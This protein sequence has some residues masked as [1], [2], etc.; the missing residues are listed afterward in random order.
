[1]TNY[2]SEIEW[3]WSIHDKLI[4]NSG[5]SYI[6]SVANFDE[7]ATNQNRKTLSLFTGF[8]YQPFHDW[9]LNFNLRKEFTNIENPPI[10]PSLGLQGTII[11]NT[12]FVFG[13]IGRHYNLPTMND[14]FWRPGGNENLKPEDAWSEELGIILTNKNNSIPKLTVTAFNSLIDN[15]IKWQPGA[16]G[17]YAPNNLRQVHTN[18]IEMSLHFH[19]EIKKLQLQFNVNYTWCNSS[20]SKT[21]TQQEAATIDK[22]LIYVPVNV[23]NSVLVLKYAH[24]SLNY[25][26][27][28]TGERFVTADN[29]SSLEPFQVANIT[30][31]KAIISKKFNIHVYTKVMNVYDVTY[32]VLA[33]RPMPG[34]WFSIGI[35]FDLILKQ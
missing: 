27:T 24:F 7:Y 28:F 32:Q 3:R 4:F 21:Q 30:I 23:L 6:N 26:H 11:K 25:N 20:I 5:V 14:L 15:W 10:A 22:Q 17:I 12:L 29:S 18:G 2:L 33:Y 31:E 34:R 13:N 1:M 35:K 9:N 19:K 8:L 16:S